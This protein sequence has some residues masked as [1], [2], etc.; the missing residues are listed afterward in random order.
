VAYAR[1]AGRRDISS[2][3]FSGISSAYSEMLN[4]RPQPVQPSFTVRQ[5]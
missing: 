5:L 2:H 3:I 4:F 1:F